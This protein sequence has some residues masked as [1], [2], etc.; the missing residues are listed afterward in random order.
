MDWTPFLTLEVVPAWLKP[1][2][3]SHLQATLI[4]SGLSTGSNLGNQS[5]ENQFQV[6]GPY[7]S[8]VSVFNLKSKV[9]SLWCWIC[10]QKHITSE[11]ADCY[12][13][14]VMEKAP[15]ME[16]TMKEVARRMRDNDAREFR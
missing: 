14:T 15:K 8:V 9:D 6:A 10:T 12:I 13:V 3:V 4:E 2:R 16:P 11:T 5:C 7:F 1:V